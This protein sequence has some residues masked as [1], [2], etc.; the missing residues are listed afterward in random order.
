QAAGL[1]ANANAS[2]SYTPTAGLTVTLPATTNLPSGWSI[3]LA[4]DQG[5]SLAVQVNATSGGHILYPLANAASQTSLTLPANFYEYMT[6]Q[7]EGS[8]HFSVQHVTPAQAQLR[9]I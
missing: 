3:G 6:L 1:G 5:K 4:T 9:G 8:G 2:S 7:Y